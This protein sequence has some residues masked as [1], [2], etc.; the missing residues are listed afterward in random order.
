MTPQS[1]AENSVVEKLVPGA[2]SLI[3]IEFT[4]PS[5]RCNSVT[6]ALERAGIESRIFEVKSCG[7]KSP[8]S[9]ISVQRGTETADMNRPEKMTIVTIIEPNMM[10]SVMQLLKETAGRDATAIL[11]SPVN[12]LASL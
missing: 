11:V 2:Q 8:P 3:R 7:C 12:Q 6:N 10:V 4:I 9:R 5:D 1:Y